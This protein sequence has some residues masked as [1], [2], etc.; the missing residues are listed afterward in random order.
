[1]KK[2]SF[3]LLFLFCW[4][5]ARATTISGTLKAPDGS[6]VNG[7]VTLHLSQEGI[8]LMTGSCGGPYIVVPIQDVSINITN[9]VFP[10]TNI[11]GNDCISPANTYY[12]VSARNSTGTLL[13]Q[14]AWTIQGTT[15]DVG[16]IVPT[17]VPSGTSDLNGTISV[18]PPGPQGPAGSTFVPGLVSDPYRDIRGYG[19]HC[20]NIDSTL[21]TPTA[22]K[23]AAIASGIGK[24]EVRVP[25]G[26]LMRVADQVN[27]QG[28]D[29]PDGWKITAG[30]GAS[31]CGTAAFATAGPIVLVNRS[32]KW[33]WDVP[34]VGTCAGDNQ[35]ISTGGLEWDN[36]GS[37]GGTS[38]D[39][40]IIP[41]ASIAAGSVFNPPAPS[42]GNQ[43]IDL[44]A[45]VGVG[46]TNANYVPTVEQNAS[47]AIV[48]GTT[49]TLT[50]DVGRNRIG[51]SS[52]VLALYA[53]GV[54]KAFTVYTPPDTVAFHTTS[55]SWTAGAG[56]AGQTLRAVIGN[57]PHDLPFPPQNQTLNDNHLSVDNVRTT[58]FTLSQG[59][60]GFE[61][62][63]A[64]VNSFTCFYPGGSCSSIGWTVGFFTI[65]RDAA[66]LT[67]Q[68]YPTD[69]S[70][71]FGNRPSNDAV[72]VLHPFVPAS[73]A[74][75]I[76]IRIGR[77][78]GVNNP[79]NCSANI[80]QSSIAKHG[81]S[82]DA[83][84][85]PDSVAILFDPFLCCDEH[86]QIG[87][88]G[89]DRIQ[90]NNS[91]DGIK[92]PWSGSVGYVF[93]S[94]VALASVYGAGHAVLNGGCPF[95][96]EY[97]AMEPGGPL[98][99]SGPD[100]GSFSCPFIVWEGQIWRHG[101]VDASE[102]DVT[103]GG[104]T[105]LTILGGNSNIKS[106]DPPFFGVE[107]DSLADNRIPQVLPLGV[108]TT[109]GGQVS[110]ENSVSQAIKDS[111][112]FGFNVNRNGLQMTATTPLINGN[113]GQNS[114]LTNHTGYYWNGSTGRNHDT[115]S[116][117]QVVPTAGNGYL[118]INHTEGTGLGGLAFGM[119][120]YGGITVTQIAPVGL[121]DGITHV[122]TAG[123]TSDTYHITAVGA[124]G[125][126][127]IETNTTNSVTA[128]S[129]AT[130]SSTNFN[131]I[132][133]R[134]PIG[135]AY[136]KVYRTSNGQA[137]LVTGVI[138][139]VYAAC[140]S[141]SFSTTA[142]PTAVGSQQ[143]SYFFNDMGANGDGT[144]PPVTNTTG[145]V[146]VP[147]LIVNGVAA[148]GAPVLTLKKGSGGGN[149][150]SASTTYAAVD[151]T[152]LTYTATIA[153]GSKL[154]I[155]AQ[156]SVTT[157]TAV[158]T[159][160]VNLTDGTCGSGTILQ[161]LQSVPTA[162][163]NP[164]SWSLGYIFTG[165][166]ASHTINLCYKTSVGAD[167]VSILNSSS[168]LLPTMTFMLGVS[169]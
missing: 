147:A 97:I 136:F 131:R 149:Y 43:F 85:L 69:G 96:I 105:T 160:S 167:S 38:T 57:L 115:T 64:A 100:P 76:P 12:V 77:C 86:W 93:G 104:E 125:E 120:I 25:P 60:A 29:I 140:P 17:I 50:A 41:T 79:T 117:G 168:S 36:N 94:N 28:T 7:R 83:G 108:A 141:A 95:H 8:A 139:K 123:G 19:G 155:Q 2:L 74:P 30:Q 65:A 63:V 129:N 22:F 51:Y 103:L 82:V 32:G 110:V 161:E 162:A 54:L 58:N 145:N 137:G 152:N 15:E 24:L 127:P 49:Y 47:A 4:L 66:I 23:D 106:I 73:L 146:V 88:K 45:D 16:V 165:D 31:L 71:T 33:T 130:L 126:T 48:N 80:E 113:V 1:M 166:G 133:W 156:G 27:L 61:S 159:A 9:G 87:G 138:G 91:A 13:F 128:T 46:G 53:N 151:G 150:S 35:N 10:S 148:A 119:P 114:P 153:T 90:I 78:I 143:A 21:T 142:C 52:S 109:E 67:A 163:T 39:A 70:E 6:L 18:G 121:I 20:Y 68:S 111:G 112:L 5:Q 3:V 124:G 42:E 59:N 122:G 72:Y 34:I 89:V 75:W 98:L 40:D 169:N 157:L 144:S 92:G 164:E 44:F 99:T 84:G 118:V 26:C 101:D 154:L 55:V 102:Y 158:A 14:E 135:A 37:T 132:V 116:I 107:A 62:P 134:G 11:V 56:E 81:G